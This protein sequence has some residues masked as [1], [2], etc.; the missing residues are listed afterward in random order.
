MAKREAVFET[1]VKGPLIKKSEGSAIRMSII[2]ID[3]VE[4]TDIRQF[5]KTK[6]GSEWLPTG[7]GF[8][9]PLDSTLSTLSKW[10]KFAKSEL[11]GS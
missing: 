7:K 6:G 10:R 8:T 4:M 2:S 9:L 5:Y 11:E 3:G 1:V